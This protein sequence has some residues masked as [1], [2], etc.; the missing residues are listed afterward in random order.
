MYPG[1]G[2]GRIPASG[3][4]RI[5]QALPKVTFRVARVCDVDVA[6]LVKIEPDQVSLSAFFF[7]WHPRDVIVA[8]V[9]LEHDDFPDMHQGRV[10]IAVRI[11]SQSLRRFGEFGHDPGFELGRR[12]RRS[13]G[14]K[15]CAADQTEQNS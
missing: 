9:I 7:R 10:E 12:R 5:Y 8:A 15:Q 6:R 11:D 1:T 2:Y 13:D 14:E 4:E 3:M